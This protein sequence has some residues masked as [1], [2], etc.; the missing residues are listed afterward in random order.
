MCVCVCQVVELILNH[1]SI[2]HGREL[3]LSVADMA[4]LSLLR[5]PKGE[6]H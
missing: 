1:P 2:L 6:W 3:R 5:E 4:H